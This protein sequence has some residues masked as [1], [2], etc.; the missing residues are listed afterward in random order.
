MENGSGFSVQR[1]LAREAASRAEDEAIKA[2][3]ILA[4][5]LWETL[6]LEHQV[7]ASLRVRE[8]FSGCLP[9][10]KLFRSGR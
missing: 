2:Q 1:V 3:W 10:E 9:I 8:Q 5:N 6:K 7:V 4:A